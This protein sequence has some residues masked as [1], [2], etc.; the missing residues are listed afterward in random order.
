L[1]QDITRIKVTGG[2]DCAVA[3]L[4]MVLGILLLMIPGLSNV[5]SVA[6]AGPGWLILLLGITI[7]V[8]GIK[9]P[10]DDIMKMLLQP[11]P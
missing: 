4:I 3:V 7:I 5:L 11:Q 9:R 2:I 10:V 8:Y 6:G 1:V